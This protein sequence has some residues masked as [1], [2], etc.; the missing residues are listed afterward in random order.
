M[1]ERISANDAMPDSDC[2]VAT[3]PMPSPSRRKPAQLEELRIERQRGVSLVKQIIAKLDAMVES[4]RLRPG[5]KTPSVR[6]LAKALE[7]S[8]F[9]VAEAYDVLVSRG[10]LSSRPGSGY[11]VTSRTAQVT[12][13]RDVPPIR[14]EAA[15]GSWLPVL[16]WNQDPD[17]LRVGSGV[18]PPEW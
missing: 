7:V 3:L 13:L 4:G 9:T 14:K 5:T 16:V 18:L 8:T 10:V 6:E 1:A 17:L 11:F 12:A 2:E 15:C